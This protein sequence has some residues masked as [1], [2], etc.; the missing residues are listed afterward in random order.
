MKRFVCSLCDERINYT[1]HRLCV[2]GALFLRV[3]IHYYQ[4]LYNN[5]KPFSRTRRFCQRCGGEQNGARG[6]NRAVNN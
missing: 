2:V 1:K 3:Q 4:H 6:T 5:K